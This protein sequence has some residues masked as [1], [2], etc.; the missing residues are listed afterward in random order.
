M[1]CDPKRGPTLLSIMRNTCWSIVSINLCLSLKERGSICGEDDTRSSGNSS[2]RQT[3][4][5]CCLSQDTHQIAEE[6]SWEKKR[7]ARE[8][9]QIS[10]CFSGNLTTGRHP[11]GWTLFCPH[12]AYS[13]CC[14]TSNSYRIS[15]LGLVSYITVCTYAVLLSS[16]FY[17]HYPLCQRHCHQGDT[18]FSVLFLHCLSSGGPTWSKLF[19]RVLPTNQVV[20]QSVPPWNCHNQW[21]STN[22]HLLKYSPDVLMHSDH[23]A[24]HHNCD[25]D[26]KSA[27]NFPPASAV[28]ALSSLGHHC[29]EG[30][31]RAVHCSDTCSLQ[32]LSFSSQGSSFSAGSPGGKEQPQ[33]SWLCSAGPLLISW[34]LFD[35]FRLWPSLGCDPSW[36]FNFSLNRLQTSATVNNSLTCTPPAFWHFCLCT[37]FL[38]F[39]FF[40]FLSVLC[41]SCQDEDGI[42][43]KLP[44]PW[45]SLETP[46]WFDNSMHNNNHILYLTRDR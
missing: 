24:T 36:Y 43:V 2:S 3:Q 21:R 10:V 8:D 39:F 40:R 31:C 20:I 5:C 6:K 23:L 30:T 38:I 27:T 18:P 44:D 15:C 46:D 25:V 13:S 14:H 11:T 16:Y 34:A 17:K 41:V 28:R 4:R 32:L 35:A 1:C 42:L 9:Q 45:W 33:K 12:T 19:C 29:L 22:S 7:D 26:I 37:V